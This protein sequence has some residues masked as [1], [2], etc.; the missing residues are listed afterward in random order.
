MMKLLFILLFVSFMASAQTDWHKWGKAEI[1]YQIKSSYTERNYGIETGTVAD[2]A[3]SSVINVYWIFFSD[4]DGD[5]CA[6]SPTCS[7]F[8]VESVK[9]TNILQGVLMFADRLTRDTNF[10]GRE[11]EYPRA[12][13]GRLYDVPSNYKLKPKDI[14]YIPPFVLVNDE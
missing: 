3:A 4:V 9:E 1:S 6:F 13:N 2:A 7:S 11:L 8:F 5:N 14:K 12:E 10:I